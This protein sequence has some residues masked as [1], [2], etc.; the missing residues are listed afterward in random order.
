[1]FI[2]LRSCNVPSA[3]GMITVK[4]ALYAVTAFLETKKNISRKK[5]RDV[6]SVELSHIMTKRNQKRLFALPTE[7]RLKMIKSILMTLPCRC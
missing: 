7:K 6:L 5:S 3:F 2:M 4:F 1:M